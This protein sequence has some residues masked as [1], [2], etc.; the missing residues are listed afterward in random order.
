MPGVVAAFTEDAGGSFPFLA[1]DSFRRFQQ[2]LPESIG[3]LVPERRDNIGI[4][5]HLVSAPSERVFRV[6]RTHV[7]DC[8]HGMKK[9]NKSAMASG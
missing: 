1:L 4:D 6:M 3:T 8:D 9:E 7:D 5:T 2:A